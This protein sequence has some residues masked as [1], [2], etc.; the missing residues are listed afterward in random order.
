MRVRS[1]D[2]ICRPHRGLS[3]LPAGQVDNGDGFPASLGPPSEALGLGGAFPSRCFL[4]APSWSVSPWRAPMR[5]AG[6]KGEVT[7]NASSR[8]VA[9]VK[10]RAPHLTITLSEQNRILVDEG[11]R[12]ERNQRAP[13]L[14]TR[15]HKNPNMRKICY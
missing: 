15:I 9:P 13:F 5:S 2:N 1:R 11:E 12:D 6:G 14:T 4:L 10:G 7:D 8:P 3:V